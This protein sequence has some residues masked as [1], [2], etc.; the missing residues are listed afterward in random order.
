VS[1]PT[2]KRW[3][4]ITSSDEQLGNIRHALTEHGARLVNEP[5]IPL[6]PDEQ[7]IKA[8]G[9]EDLPSVLEGHPSIRKVSPDSEIQLHGG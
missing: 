6:E 5:P 1:L 9:P 2:M 3:L 8:E 7:V 4:V